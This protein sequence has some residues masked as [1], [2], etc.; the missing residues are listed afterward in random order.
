MHT[1]YTTYFWQLLILAVW[2][3]VGISVGCIHVQRTDTEA[4]WLTCIWLTILHY[5]CF[6]I[7]ATVDILKANF[8]NILVRCLST[9]H[10]ILNLINFFFG[11]LYLN[12]ASIYKRF[13]FKIWDREPEKISFLPTH[14]ESSGSVNSKTNIVLRLALLAATTAYTRVIPENCD[15]FW[16]AVTNVLSC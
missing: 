5:N 15:K 11:L 14:P 16:F 3:I 2:Y 4:S 6:S 13:S 12:F 8:K 9:H 7:H 10:F 1:V